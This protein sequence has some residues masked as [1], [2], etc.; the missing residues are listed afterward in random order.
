MGTASQSA[1]AQHTTYEET[2]L[3]YQ[4]CPAPRGRG[5]SIGWGDGPCEN[6]PF[7]NCATAGHLIHHSRQKAKNSV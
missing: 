4:K 2:Q 5:S 6:S 3:N 1:G 7:P